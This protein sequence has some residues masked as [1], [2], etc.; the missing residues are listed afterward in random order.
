MDICKEAEATFAT[1]CEKIYKN[2]ANIESSDIVKYDH[3]YFDAQKELVANKISEAKNAIEILQKTMIQNFNCEIHKYVCFG[4]EANLES[5]D[6]EKI[7]KNLM[8]IINNAYKDLI[9]YVQDETCRQLNISL[10]TYFR[11]FGTHNVFNHKASEVECMYVVLKENTSFSQNQIYSLDTL[12]ERKKIISAY[13]KLQEN[14]IPLTSS[15]LKMILVF[16]KSVCSKLNLFDMAEM[17]N[18]YLQ[19]KSNSELDSL[20][21]LLK[22]LALIILDVET[23][24]TIFNSTT[25]ILYEYFNFTYN[26]KKL[27]QEIIAKEALPKL[28]RVVGHIEVERCTLDKIL[29]I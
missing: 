8:E 16:K 1:M 11:L 23:D 6:F 12:K 27:K 2:V 18:Y 28:A 10:D 17:S 24:P 3:T 5:V 21:I 20:I 26:K 22:L 4:S 7:E 15:V 29:M 13:E 14:N 9:N 19:L 25:S